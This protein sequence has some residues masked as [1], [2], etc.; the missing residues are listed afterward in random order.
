[1]KRTEIEFREIS[2]YINLF[3]FD[4]YLRK[5]TILITG[6]KGLVGTGL[7]KWILMEN[8]MKETNARII[9]STR[10]PNET[11]SYIENTDN[12]IYCEYGKEDL[13]DER[14][15][16]IIHAASPTGNK[17]HMQHP[18]ETFKTNVDGMEKMLEIAGRNSGCSMIYLSSEEV[19]GLPSDD[20]PAI[21]EDMVGAIDSL[22]LR[23]CY[24]LGKKA[25]EFLCYA[26]AEQYGIDVKIIRPTVIHGLFQRYEETR[27]VNELLQC[28]LEN[29]NFV[30]QSDGMTKKCMMYSLDAI[31]A[32]FTVLFLGKKGEA[33]NV[34]NIDTFL[35]VKDLAQHL[36]KTFNP[37]IKVVFKTGGAAKADGFLPHRTIVQNCTKLMNLGWKPYGSLDH[38]YEVDLER[39]KEQGKY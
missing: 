3:D 18:V 13:V 14:I 34:S 8:E 26:S 7:V 22:N 12:I 19:Y 6:S 27:V 31:S 29:K 15:D 5:K 17:Y 39:F 24:P 21:T 11:P 20:S 36:I 16:Y 30:M 4:K 9:A 35:T 25:S 10:N 33:Y 38:I 1:M 23:S 28:L 37:N 32:I 2:K